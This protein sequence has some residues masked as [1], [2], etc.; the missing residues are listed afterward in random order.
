MQFYIFDAHKEKLFCEVTNRYG[1]KSKKPYD[2]LN[3]ALHVGDDP[4]TVIQNRTI[5][6][7]E[8]NFIAEN[9]I[10]MEQTHS[11]NI[12]I[13]EHCGLNKIKNCDAIIT[14]KP[15]IPL[16]VMV[17]DCIPIM[18]YDPIQ[19]VIAA[20]HAGRNGTFKKIATKTLL[21]M[22]EHY[23]TN[24]QDVL[25]G[26]GTSIHSC[27]YEVGEDLVDI[28]I[29]NF[30]EKYIQTKD[31]KR[32][33]NLQTLNYDQLT[34]IGVKSKNIEISP[35]CSCCNKD[36]FSYRREGTTGRFCGLIKLK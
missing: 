8:Y 28:T 26:F 11:D 18:M 15:N 6:S 22:Q 17:A 9:L 23:N 35:I 21:K 12:Q 7:K 16:M 24:F 1:G 30:G 27:C 32:Y 4:L 20:V 19:N 31:K 14:N 25:I 10:Y 34:Q 5:L 2:S 29:K 3:L 36:Y 33:L 13:I